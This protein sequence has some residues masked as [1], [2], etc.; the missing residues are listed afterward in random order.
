MPKTVRTSSNRRIYAKLW[1]LHIALILGLSLSAWTVFRVMPLFV[2]GPPGK[3]LIVS[4]GMV[5]LFIIVAGGLFRSK[6]NRGALEKL[7][8][9][10][11]DSASH[12]KWV[13]TQIICSSLAGW[14][15]L[16]GL[17]IHLLG[18]GNRGAMSFLGLGAA[19]MVFW[20]PKRP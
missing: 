6:R 7:R 5:S 14:I 2:P 15:V 4:L 12:A 11:D 8:M 19:M 1:F 9:T 3:A 10:P 20:I 17:L 16:F 13:F 18:G